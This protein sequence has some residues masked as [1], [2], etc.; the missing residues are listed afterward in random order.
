MFQG[1]RRELSEQNG[2]LAKG[3][4]MHLTD[5]PTDR[6][7]KRPLEISTD[8]RLTDRLID[9]LTLPIARLLIHSPTQSSVSIVFQSC[10]GHSSHYS[11]FSWF[12]KY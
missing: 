12:H 3:S 2:A 9:S 5:R 1:N 10:H 7:S 11:C 8:E 4:S 6:L